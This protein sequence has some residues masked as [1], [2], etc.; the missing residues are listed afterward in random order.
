MV[1]IYSFMLGFYPRSFQDDF[2]DE[3]VDVFDA[4]MQDAKKRSMFSALTIFI[5][6]IIVI[7]FTAGKEHLTSSTDRQKSAARTH[8]NPIQFTNG[9]FPM[10]AKDNDRFMIEDHR[11]TLFSTLAPMLIGLGIS[12]TWFIIGAPWYISSESMRK[13]AIL[14]G[15]IPALLIA[16]VCIWAFLKKTPAWSAT[17]L[18]TAITGTAL[19]IQSLA[20]DNTFFASS[21][22]YALIAIFGIISLMI[23]I[24]IALRNY[25]QAGLLGIGLSSMI[26]LFQCHILSAG[27]TYHFWIGMAAILPGLL[28]SAMAY[29]FIRATQMKDRV[30]ILL[31]TAVLNITGVWLTARIY[32]P[33]LIQQGKISFAFPLAVIVCIALISGLLVQFARSTYL[34]ILSKR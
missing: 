17:W 3:M 27:P 28:F 18:G 31:G 11:T 14:I 7:P 1:L 9:R 19:V 13:L 22:G 10:K 12:I 5:R 26:T 33:Y 21:Y 34:K 25:Q 8:L 15:S 6:E 24:T 30:I 23:A 29:L 2:K 32:S 16:A 20:E 4:L